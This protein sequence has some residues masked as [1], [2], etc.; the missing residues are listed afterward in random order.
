[1]TILIINVLILTAIGQGQAVAK[2]QFNKLIFLFLAIK[3][4]QT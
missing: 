2:K 3:L 4:H 1:M